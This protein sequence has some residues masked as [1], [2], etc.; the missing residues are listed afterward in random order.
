MTVTR[1]GL[2]A[3][4]IRTATQTT[5][6]DHCWANPGTPCARGLLAAHAVRL[7]VAAQRNLIPAA[8]LEAA[9]AGTDAQN[10]TLITFPEV[11]S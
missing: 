4:A 5:R 3:T 8:A 9:L 6:C 7:G 2:I 10:H 11:T 1:P